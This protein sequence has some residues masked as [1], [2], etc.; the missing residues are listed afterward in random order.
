MSRDRRSHTHCFLQGHSTQPRIDG[1]LR[2]PSHRSKDKRTTQRISG[3]RRDRSTDPHH[4]HM[5][6]CPYLRSG[7]LLIRSC[8]EQHIVRHQASLHRSTD[9]L[10]DRPRS[11]LPSPSASAPL[12]TS[13]IRRTVLR[14]DLRRDHIPRL[15]VRL[16][17]IDLPGEL[18]KSPGA[19]D[20]QSVLPAAGPSA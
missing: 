20:A 10:V 7:T 6:P 18:E 16:S 8:L 19:H 14:S 12:D 15:H 9:L 17:H 1:R 2:K 5:Q 11:R 3:V 4:L 13:P